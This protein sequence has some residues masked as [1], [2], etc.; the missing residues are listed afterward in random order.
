MSGE[1]LTQIANS[2]GVR[3][4]LAGAASFAVT[5]FGLPSCAAE[6]QGDNSGITQPAPTASTSPEARLSFED[7]LIRAKTQLGGDSYYN[8]RKTRSQ[9]DVWQEAQKSV[10][11]VASYLRQNPAHPV[12]TP[13]YLSRPP[14]P[15][16]PEI[17]VP[18]DSTMLINTRK[19]N[20]KDQ[21]DFLIAGAMIQAMTSRHPFPPDN[22]IYRNLEDLHGKVTFD[23]VDMPPFADPKNLALFSQALKF[24]EAAGKPVP[25]K[26]TLDRD[27]G[28]T[29]PSGQVDYFRRTINKLGD[30]YLNADPLLFD[31]YKQ[32]VDQA[33]AQSGTE[34]KYPRLVA[35]QPWGYSWTDE[36]D[37]KAS[38]DKYF[39][40]GVSFRKR[41]TYLQEKGFTQE[42][43]IM[44]AKYD[45]MRSWFGAEVLA[46]G[47]VVT[48]EPYQKGEVAQIYD[49][50][51]MRNPKRGGIFLRPTATL[52]INPEW[53]STA[54]G[55]IVRI[56]AGPILAIDEERQEAV[57]MWKVQEGTV[58]NRIG[59][60]RTEDSGEG[61]I[62]EEWFTKQ[63]AY[64][65]RR[66]SAG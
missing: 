56:V 53:P 9:E 39:T 7:Y 58:F 62:S 27:I 8:L 23:N 45:A 48:Q 12:L 33:F 20:L 19:F 35:V 55:K 29:L 64:R 41:L 14:L 11:A 13:E 49:Y 6:G 43:N 65:Q 37:F 28:S 5:G 51:A 24:F 1:R 61:W 46:D 42:Y 38:F 47:K 40:D 17:I 4:A 31:N 22:D 21:T 60:R 50:V 59:F 66:Q 2:K 10:V 32:G 63:I 36:Q 30:Y 54:H 34:V 26:W 57:N 44:S 18:N 16:V 15:F 25:E 52:A 3:L